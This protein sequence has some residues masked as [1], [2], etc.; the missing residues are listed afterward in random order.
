MFREENLR[1]LEETL[2]RLGPKYGD[3]LIGGD[4]NVN[5]LHNNSITRLF[6][7]FC[8][9][10]GLS[11]VNT[12]WPTCFKSDVNPSLLDMFLTSSRRRILGNDQIRPTSDFIHDFIFCSYEF[13]VDRTNIPRTVSYRSYR[14]FDYEDIQVNFR[15][16]EWNEIYFSPDV[17]TKV[18]LFN[19]LL[20]CLYDNY[21]DG[22]NNKTGR[23]ALTMSSL[24]L[25]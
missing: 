22:Q 3:I 17:N 4:F 21:S 16:L 9:V 15:S 19:N 11:V 23:D 18:S 5:F 20:T 6:K 1:E 2:L 14:G 10:M 8:D 24:S 7:H 25:R 12:Q 13:D